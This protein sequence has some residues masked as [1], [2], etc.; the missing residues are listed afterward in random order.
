MMNLESYTR[1]DENAKISGVALIPRISRNHNLYTKE[2]L[3]RFDGITVPLN[4]E[5]NGDKV[6]GK[7]TFRYNAET[8]TVFYEGEITD[9]NAAILAKNRILYTSIEATPMSV[10]Q[11][12]NGD[13]DCFHMPYG[14]QP[15]GLALTET[16][17]VPETSVSI[18]EKYIAE[19]QHD[20]NEYEQYGASE[21]IH[22]TIEP[23]KEA[24]PCWK[25]YKQ[26][27]MKTQDGKEVPNCVP[28]SQAEAMKMCDHCN[29]TGYHGEQKCPKCNGTG[30]VEES[31]NPDDNVDN[32][33]QDVVK[34][35]SKSLEEQI[36]YKKQALEIYKKMAEYSDD[37]LMQ[38]Q[39][40]MLNDDI[41][42]MTHE[43]LLLRKDSEYISVESKLK[44]IVEELQNQFICSDCG[45]LK[46]K[47][48]K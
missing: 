35:K 25:G 30:M 10:K 21:I 3:K 47:L 33:M 11:V 20:H 34:A 45:E 4:W 13:S 48:N 43:L 42:Q 46:K 8:E 39:I 36:K 29:G 40:A 22:K 14:L 37:P 12:C 28:E 44:D 24:D 16:P 31:I 23:R 26:V 9:P 6:I 41:E 19:C 38:N 2:E 27:G 18:I 15:Q 7:A 5:H 1:I 32:V 17:G